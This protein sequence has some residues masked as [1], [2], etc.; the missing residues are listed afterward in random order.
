MTPAESAL[1]PLWCR[2]KC[3]LEYPAL[4]VG[5]ADA[6]IIRGLRADFSLAR[7]SDALLYALREL[8]LAA[9]AEEYLAGHPRA[10]IVSLGCGLDTLPRRLGPA[11]GARI[12]VDLPEVIALRRRLL[13]EAEGET[14][15]AADLAR[16]G[17]REP[18]PAGDGAFFLMGG[19]LCHL[20]AGASAGLLG[21]LGA[22][23]PGAG[24]AF[25]G[26]SPLA[27]R[28]AGMASALPGEAE[29]SRRCS[30]S[31][32]RVKRLPDAFAA[33]PAGRRLRLAALLHTGALRFYAGRC[34]HNMA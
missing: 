27:R 25:D 3:A 32:K 28:L 15:I 19:L 9:A 8:L 16:G 4:G 6:G 10:A 2:A 18:V 17:F 23:Y 13:P 24:L 30:L 7:R 1:L 29:L 21:G 11:H 20:D 5:G 31:V 34:G 22:D 12:Y 14:Y 33:V 26:L